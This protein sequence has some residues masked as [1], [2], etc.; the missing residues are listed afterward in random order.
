M[1]DKRL[2]FCLSPGR[3][4]TRYLAEMLKL[5]PGVHV[6]HEGR[7]DFVDIARYSR[8]DRERAKRWWVEKKLPAIE[9]TEGDI[10][11]ETSHLFGKGPCEALIELGV[12]FDVI[13]LTRDPRDV[14]LSLWQRGSI[15]GRTPRGIA[16]LLHPA[17]P[18]Y[19]ALEGWRGLNDYQLCYW[20]ATEGQCPGNSL[21]QNQPWVTFDQLISGDGFSDLVKALDLPAPNWKHWKRVRHNRYNEN[22]EHLRGR[23]PPGDLDAMEKEVRDAITSNAVKRAPA[24]PKRTAVDIAVLCGQT[25]HKDLAWMLMAMAN[26]PKYNKYRLTISTAWGNP[27]SSNR[28]A[29]ARE[30][31]FNESKPEWLAMIDDDTIP[32]PDFLDVLDWYADVILFPAPCWK[33]MTGRSTL[34]VVW[35]LETDAGTFVPAH[36]LP[37]PQQ[38]PIL[39][40]R[41]GGTGALLIR[42]AVIEHPVMQ[43]PFRDEFDEDGVRSVGHDLT[44]CHRAREAGFEVAAS[45]RHLCEHFNDVPLKELAATL[46]RYEYAL[47]Q[48]T[49]PKKRKRRKRSK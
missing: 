1:T 29:I 30:F 8:Q 35:N 23:M 12:P 26:D 31:R 2:I 3:C 45:L 13:V 7:P 44:F 22:P 21:P 43:W 10:Y 27:T 6:E 37:N 33:P 38:A 4:G 46:A 20:Y 28:N 18:S 9:A 40:V 5:C 15:P 34:P 16:Y 32:P 48:A 49:Q 24:K 11:V 36:L 25:V 39:P 41:G 17:E 19:N 14:A 42:R 47:V